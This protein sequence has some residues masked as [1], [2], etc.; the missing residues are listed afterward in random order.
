MSELQNDGSQ[1]IQTLQMYRT[2]L[3]Q[4][5]SIDVVVVSLQVLSLLTQNL[6]E[7]IRWEGS[8]NVFMESFVNIL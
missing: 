3:M 2:S 8:W 5:E 6:S 1:N 4:P 7:N